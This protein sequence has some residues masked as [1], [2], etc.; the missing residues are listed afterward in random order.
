MKQY[1]KEWMCISPAS[2]LEQRRGKIGFRKD[3][4]LQISKNDQTGF[5]L[6]TLLYFI[7]KCS[8]KFSYTQWEKS[9]SWRPCTNKQIK[10]KHFS[11]C[12]RKRVDM[13]GPADWKLYIIG[14]G[15]VGWYSESPIDCIWLSE[16]E[17]NQ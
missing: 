1:M 17:E 9:L 5:C 11:T 4:R 14:Y 3:F 6:M 8:I 2:K 13:A 12:A 16:E 7:F 15:G 10:R